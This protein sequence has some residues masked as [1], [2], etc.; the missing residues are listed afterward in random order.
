MLDFNDHAPLLNESYR[1]WSGDYIVAEK[2]PG[3]VL[4]VLNQAN[5]V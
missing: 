5:F 3:E 4:A 1:H 2:D